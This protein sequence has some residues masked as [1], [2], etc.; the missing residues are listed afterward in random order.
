[1]VMFLGRQNIHMALKKRRTL[2]VSGI[3][4]YAHRRTRRASTLLS[5]C[6]VAKVHQ[7]DGMR[8][9]QKVTLAEAPGIH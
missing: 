7:C 9:G 8:L 4:R 1:M 5:P 2:A 3:R 6:P